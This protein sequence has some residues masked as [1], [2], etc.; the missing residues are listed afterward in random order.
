MGKERHEY[1]P[2]WVFKSNF[3]LGAGAGAFLN[4]FLAVYL[5]SIGFGGTEIGIMA[6]GG[7]ASGYIGTIVWSIGGDKTLRFRRLFLTSFCGG[8]VLWTLFGLPNWIF[9]HTFWV[10]FF[11]AMCAAFFNSAQVGLLDSFVATVTE[12]SKSETYGKQ[13]MWFPIGWG[14]WSLVVGGVIHEFGYP[15]MFWCYAILEGINIG[16]IMTYFPS[17]E[18]LQGL[19]DDIALTEEKSSRKP[20]GSLW[21]I[22]K[23]TDFIL[24]MLHLLLYASC[25]SVIDQ[26]FLVYLSDYYNCTAI[27]MGATIWV[28][29]I[30]E[31]VVFYF[32][33]S[34]IKW[35]TVKGS[36]IFSAFCFVFRAWANT[37]VD[38]DQVFWFLPLQLMHGFTY[39]LVWTCVVYYGVEYVPVRY[40][41]TVIGV[42][43][44]TYMFAGRGLGALVAGVIYKNYGPITLYRFASLVCLVW[45]LIYSGYFAFYDQSEDLKTLVTPPEETPLLPMRQPKD[46]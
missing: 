36:L 3:F 34:I 27:F 19:I 1:I 30:S 9:P 5:S 43:K 35:F 21:D 10:I 18:E 2:S 6:A 20:R 4:S 16:V 31:A 25:N 7:F 29:T 22:A 17:K 24:Y 23:K 44:A 42:A 15:S 41:N 26:F 45:T 14:L 12:K 33:D 32:S 28:M 46:E 39:S 40:R 37:M 38:K 11:T 13:K 8:T